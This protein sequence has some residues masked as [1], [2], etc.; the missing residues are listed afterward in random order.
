MY[1]KLED[2][3]D[4]DGIISKKPVQYS[5]YLDQMLDD[6]NRQ[7]AVCVVSLL[8]AALKQVTIDIPAITSIILQ[9][10]NANTY[11]NT[12]LICAIAILNTWYS[13]NFQLKITTFIHTETQD[14]KT[15]LDAHFARCMRYLDHF[16]KTWKRN[17]ITR[18]NTPNGL[19][20]ALAYN[21]GMT[22]VMVQVVTTNR[23][24]VSKIQH[25]FDPVMK[26]MKQYFTRVNH[27][28]FISNSESSIDLFDA[29]DED[30]IIKFVKDFKFDIGVQAYSNVGHMAIFNVNVADASVTPDEFVGNEIQFNLTGEKQTLVLEEDELDGS[31]GDNECITPDMDN[32]LLE[33]TSE[34]NDF[35][36]ESKDSKQHS[37]SDEESIDT[38]DYTSDDQTEN[39]DLT[40]TKYAEKRNYCK[41]NQTHFG[42]S[43][44]ITRPTISRILQLGGARKR[45]IIK[46]NDD[47][48]K[49][50]SKRK[51]TYDK[52]KNER[53]D[54]IAKAIRFSE[55]YI[56]TG[57][58]LIKD[59]KT[60]DQSL[61]V[62]DEFEL[63]NEKFKKGWAR[64]SKAEGGLYGRTFIED[65]KDDI[66]AFFTRG[67]VN[68]SEK[69][70]AAQ[71]REALVSKYPNRF[72]I[73]SETEIKQKISSI[74]ATSKDST[75]KKTKKKENFIFVENANGT[76]IDWT[77]SLEE[78]VSTNRT[79]KPEVIYNEFVT[80]MTNTHTVPFDNLPSKEDVKKKISYF[81]QRQKKVAMNVVV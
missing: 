5:V 16:M 75:R 43:T 57:C 77:N 22:N 9:S 30:D 18:I 17:K 25:I 65:Y 51:K 71:M 45:K 58:L 38:D 61:M 35:T 41:P 60:K 64:R 8:D 70:N 63:N 46:D 31:S 80:L 49:K 27:V 14:G 68:S 47:D 67:N 28:E 72:C 26:K 4:D 48:T 76:A 66:E 39:E 74:F 53:I 21:G 29:S 73:P 33:R 32:N 23:N 2:V 1:Y 12:F 13:I 15:V 78:I 24:F 42:S 3:E 55:K 6:G 56:S 54:V 10:D 69:M 40:S 81:K 36:Y 37:T 7:D 11:Q 50:K 44:M 34:K 59:G 20:F 79:E 52:Y 19:G 62:A